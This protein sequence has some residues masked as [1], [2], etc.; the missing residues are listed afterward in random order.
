MTSHDGMS[1]NGEFKTC[2]EKLRLNLTV[3]PLSVQEPYCNQTQ[4]F[5]KTDELPE[6]HQLLT[7]T[8]HN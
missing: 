2:D 5:I 4:L 1:T 6:V 8:T 3:I 7:Q